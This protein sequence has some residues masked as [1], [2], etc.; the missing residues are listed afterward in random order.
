MTRRLRMHAGYQWRNS[1]HPAMTRLR[2]ALDTRDAAV[3]PAVTSHL[4]GMSVAY[5]GLAEGLAYTLEFTE[6]RREADSGEAAQRT[7][8]KLTG[9]A[10]Q[11][12]ARLPDADIT[13]VGTSAV[14]ARRLPGR[15]SLIMPMRVHFVIDTDGDPDTVCRKISKRERTQF[16]RDQRHHDWTW[17]VERDP[18]WFDVFYDRHYRPTMRARHGARER[19]ETKDVSYECLFRTGRLFSLWQDGERIG[20]SLCH[21]DATSRVLTLRLLGVADGSA[22]HYNS[23]AFKAI[24]HFLIGWAAENGV[25]HLDFQGTEPFLSKG[26]YQWKRRFGTRVVLPP[27][28]FGNKRLWLH[29][30]RDTPEVRDFLVANPVLTET[31]DGTLEAAYFHDASRPARQD[32]SAKSPGVERV[33]HL[34]LDT[35]LASVPE[36]KRTLS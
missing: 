24:Y 9:K 19:T 1:G 17:T 14:R 33:R 28:H 27:N 7:T 22:E 32:Y 30:R 31:A 34:D 26:T 18:A 4:G 36:P 10:L 25:R 35:F 3:F 21:W 15:A 13:I 23:G 11:S 29:V 6:L 20:G 12:P 8:V 16:N 2:T 5:S